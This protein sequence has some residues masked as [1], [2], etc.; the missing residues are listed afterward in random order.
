VIAPPAVAHPDRRR[1]L[2]RIAQ[3]RWVA[4]GLGVAYAASGLHRGVSAAPLLVLAATAAAYNTAAAWQGRWPRLRSRTVVLITLAGDFVW[5]TGYALAVFPLHDDFAAVVGYVVLGS[6][7]GLLL[8]WRGAAAAVALGAAVLVAF[9]A[10][11]GRGGTAMAGVVGFQAGTVAVA[12]VFTSVGAAELRVQQGE[13]DAKTAAI[14]RH[15]RTDHL[16][17]LGN[18]RVVEETLARLRGHA[19]GLLLVDID[20]MRW[21]NVVYGHEAGDEM[22]LAVARVLANVSE[23]GD[24]PCRLGEDKFALLLPGAGDVRTSAVA[25][26]VHTAMATV[27]VSTAELRVSV[28]CAWSPGGD[29]VATLENADDA[30]YAA[31]MRGGGCIVAQGA[32]EHGSRWRLRNAVLSALEKERG[33]YSVYQQIVSL[34]DGGTV[35]WEAL[36]R[37]HHW[38]TNASVEALFATAHRM[39]RGRELDW[40]CRRN[41]LWEASRLDGPLFVNIN[42][43]GLLDPVHGVD[44]M[45]LLCRWAQRDPGQVVLELSERDAIP[46]LRRLHR[47]LTDYRAAGFR[48]ALDDLGEGQTT[49]EVVLG[50]Q[51]DF[52]KLARPLLQSARG[53]AAAHSVVRALVTFAHDIGSTVIAEG[54]EDDTDRQLCLELGIDLGQGW[55]FGRPL[56]A[57]RLPS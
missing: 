52:L 53:E 32:V 12:G 14:E 27:S 55:L 21:T 3:V 42:V 18:A 54:V 39:G 5:I 50:A 36:S 13:L 10:A 41:A 19:H 1:L 40:R 33:I 48:F 49:L 47:V 34:T 30:L 9:A 28:G 7:C 29:D 22:L 57:E 25:S 45:Q 44:Q 46:D 17:G 15:A 35:G 56:P 23:N 24:I 43:S 20:G 16:T 26:A 8:G 37:P 6:E 51:P 2:S 38:P 11:E 31:K 4:I